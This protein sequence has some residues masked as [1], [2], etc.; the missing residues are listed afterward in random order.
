LPFDV[1]RPADQHH[2]D[3]LIQQAIAI[4]APVKLR[5]LACAC[6]RLLVA[7]FPEEW[8]LQVFADETGDPGGHVSPDDWPGSMLLETI[9]ITEVFCPTERGADALRSVHERAQ[10]LAEERYNDWRWAD[11]KLGDSA[12]GAEY[13]VGI[14]A[15]HVA[16]A[17]RD[18]TSDDIH[19]SIRSCVQHTIEA[20]AFRWQELEKAAATSA[21][22]EAM[23]RLIRDTALR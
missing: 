6:C 11:A 1:I 21:E 19:S 22:R 4:A 15:W 9:R 16:T 18:C 3:W 13:E 10:V 2:L 7:R 14:I 5:Q 8:P 20:L 23:A 17:A 12:T